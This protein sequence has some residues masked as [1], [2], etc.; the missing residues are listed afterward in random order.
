MGDRR[1]GD[2]Q[3][4]IDDPLSSSLQ[5]RPQSRVEFRHGLVD[6]DDPDPVADR[7]R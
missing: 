5:P 1:C 7:V 4:R 2:K 6:S 3:I